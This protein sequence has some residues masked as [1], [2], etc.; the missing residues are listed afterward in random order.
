[1]A[2]TG[3]FKHWMT[4]PLNFKQ[5]TGVHI[6]WRTPSEM[7]VYESQSVTSGAMFMPKSDIC[8]YPRHS[9]MSRFLY[10]DQGKIEDKNNRVE[11]S[12]TTYHSKILK[13]PYRGRGVAKES[14]GGKSTAAS[15]GKKYLPAG[16]KG[17]TNSGR[18]KPEY[19]KY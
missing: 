12:Y 6:V 19:F 14:S 10:I 5:V 17:A 4:L 15:R 9:V 2:L 18:G 3:N 8:S 1:M 7:G 16:R 11:V 13:K